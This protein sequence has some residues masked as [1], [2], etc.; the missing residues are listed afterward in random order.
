MRDSFVTSGDLG[1][2]VVAE[3]QTRGIRMARTPMLPDLPASWRSRMTPDISGRPR[4]LILD[5]RGCPFEDI[6]AFCG[7]LFL[8]FRRG[9]SLAAFSK[10]SVTA[11]ILRVNAPRWPKTQDSPND[12]DFDFEISGGSG[13][14][15]RTDSGIAVFFHKFRTTTFAVGET[16]EGVRI[17]FT[18]HKTV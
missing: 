6:S 12:R 14:F 4:S 1:E 13:H 10:Q 11:T 16:D 2:F 5:V 18:D 3:L 8:P 7:A 17:S 15:T 9:P